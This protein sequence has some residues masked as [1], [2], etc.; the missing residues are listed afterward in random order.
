MVLD[1]LVGHEGVVAV[2]VHVVAD[3]LK[4]SVGQEHVVSS[5][6]Y[7]VRR[8]GVVVPGLLVSVVASDLVVDDSVAKLVPRSAL[9]KDS[10]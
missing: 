5:A 10:S 3:P 1:L 6:G 4:F 9:E 7:S 8:P 2:L